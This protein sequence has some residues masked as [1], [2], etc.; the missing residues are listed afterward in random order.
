MGPQTKNSEKCENVN[1]N[2]T[3]KKSTKKKVFWQIFQNLDQK[4]K[5]IWKSTSTKNVWK[6]LLAIKI[7][8]WA[9][10]EVSTVF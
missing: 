2:E 10:G 8:D 5:K 1:V 6:N 7:V 4:M 3:F 9:Y